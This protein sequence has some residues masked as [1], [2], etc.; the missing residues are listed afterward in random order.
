MP[1]PLQV[2]FRGL[3][4]S[5]A[6]DRMV[7]DKA[8]RLERFHERI[9]SCHVTID[10]PPQHHRKG[11]TFHVSVKLIVPGGEIVASRESGKDHAHE[12]VYVA[13]R[14][15]FA[16]VVRQ[17]EDHV[18]HRRDAAK[19]RDVSLRRGAAPAGRSQEE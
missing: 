4:P 15:A 7:R 6:I 13:L 19:A 17:V 9:A 11:G 12:D 5:E 16:A 18:R 14:D 3:E 10:A 8:Q 1:L 2:T